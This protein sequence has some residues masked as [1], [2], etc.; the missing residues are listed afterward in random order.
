ML[1]R[2]G[3]KRA[4]SAL[5]YMM[6]YGWAI[7][8]IVIVAAVLYSFGIFNPSSNVTSAPLI[9]GFSDVPVTS[10]AVNSSFFKVT[11]TDQYGQTIRINNVTLLDGSQLF[12][13]SNCTN[14]I[15]FQGQYIGCYV[16]GTFTGSPV[17]VLGT[18][19]YTVISNGENYSTGGTIRL[20]KQSGPLFPP[21]QFFV[22][23]FKESGLPANSKWVTLY[24][25]R[26]NS[27]T[28]TN[29]SFLTQAGDFSYEVYNFSSG[30]TSVGCSSTTYYYPSIK[31]GSLI[32]GNNVTET[33]TGTSGTVCLTSF[34]ETGLPPS[35]KWNVTYDG[36]T[37]SS[38]SSAID[39]ITLSGTFSYTVPSPSNSSGNCNTTYTPSP[40]S[41]TETAG[42]SLPIAFTPSTT[43]SGS[44]IVTTFIES[45]LPSGYS[46]NVTYDGQT[47]S[48][49]S[50]SIIIK[51][52][53]GSF[54]F[55]VYNQSSANTPSPGFTTTYTGNSTTG[56][57]AAGTS[58]Y[59][60]FSNKTKSLYLFVTDD[61][62]N[63]VYV[64]DP[65]TNTIIKTVFGENLGSPAGIALSPNGRYIYVANVY[66][67]SISKI[68]TSNYSLAGV[69]DT[70]PGIQSVFGVAL[71]PNGK[72][73]YAL[74][75]NVTS[76]QVFNSSTDISIKNISIPLGS[77]N[78]GGVYPSYNGKLLAAGAGKG[79]TIINVSNMS[80]IKSIINISVNSAN[81]IAWSPDSKKIYVAQSYSSSSKYN[82]SFSVVNATSFAF[83]AQNV[84]TP[85]TGLEGGSNIL[86]NPNGKFAYFTNAFGSSLTTFVVIN[87]TSNTALTRFQNLYEPLGEILS[88]N[89]LYLTLPYAPAIAAIN[90]SNT[91]SLSLTGYISD[92]YYVGGIAIGANGF[93]YITQAGSNSLIRV[94]A[95][96]ISQ[97]EKFIPFSGMPT[98]ALESG[99]SVQLTPNGKFAYVY[100][101][102]LSSGM[103]TIYVLNTS[104]D[105]LLQT[106]IRVGITP[107]TFDQ[108]S[109]NPTPEG[110]AISSNGGTA[111]V[112]NVSGNHLSTGNNLLE[113]NTTTN[114]VSGYINSICPSAKPRLS[115]IAVYLPT[116]TGYVDCYNANT[117]EIINTS[118]NS[119]T[120][121]IS[122]VGYPSG[123][124]INGSASRL[125][126]GGGSGVDVINTSTNS[127][128]HTIGLPVS[129]GQF[130][131]Y[132]TL[133]TNGN[134]YV[135]H[136]ND[137][138]VINPVTYTYIANI[139]LGFAGFGIAL[140]PNDKT[141]LV[142][143]EAS[144]AGAATPYDIGILNLTTNQLIR[145]Y[146]GPL[147]L[148]GE[149]WGITNTNNPPESS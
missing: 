99:D 121:S 37:N 52:I 108:F 139:S 1:R 48:S 87:A 24:N 148:T 10:A 85:F 119:V 147:S 11:I 129:P 16:K 35:Y 49:T 118:S 33:F 14:I 94:N 54:S 127:V 56:S 26:L 20:G 17:S 32:A 84:S 100:A 93:G 112:L 71:S 89:V 136:G 124:A 13:V 146:T 12:T 39:I 21:Q 67:N 137:V 113:I 72:L 82:V 105:K 58:K 41:G 110:I 22:S 142:T 59:V 2:S 62:N 66:N 15:L 128:I 83:I 51:T 126:V 125:Y 18:I 42:N 40:N 131:S 23:L 130:V 134:L 144:G 141:A 86:V 117:T 88:N 132:M 95:T 9:T 123:V 96:N 122:V 57:F 104:N 8:I 109:G 30:Q 115:S 149:P 80:D 47:N 107:S 36:V 19:H 63:S 70:I 90:V 25:D 116:N 65:S 61:A 76:L 140:L 143:S 46:W 78:A 97:P 73:L 5:E 50:S 138:Y 111:Y 6:A 74:T 92:P 68:R 4:Q 69:I 120:G 53:S 28:T 98:S 44:N 60:D 114:A 77:F 43:C 133:G 38:T 103:D 55:D 45:G 81:G 91:S 34:S 27:S 135:A 101:D 79:V 75:R 106:T 102:N 145:I 29:I 3:E 64:L 7:L 31:S